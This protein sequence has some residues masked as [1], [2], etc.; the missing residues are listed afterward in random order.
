MMEGWKNGR[1]DGLTKEMLNAPGCAYG[2]G[3][4]TRVVKTTTAGKYSTINCVQTLT[5]KND[6]V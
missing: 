4:I 2:M 3:S 6:V 1:I 5:F